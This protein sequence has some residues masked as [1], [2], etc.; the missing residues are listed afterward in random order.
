[1]AQKVTENET[2]KVEATPAVPTRNKTSRTRLL[3]LLSGTCALVIIALVLVGLNAYIYIQNQQYIHNQQAQADGQYQ[4]SSG[5]QGTDLG[6]TP[7]PNFQLVDQNGKSISLQQFHGHPVVLTFLYTTCPGPCPLTA[8]KLSSAVKLLGP[9]TSSKV[10]WLAVSLSPSTDNA[11]LATAFVNAHGLTGYMHYL[12]GSQQQLS[13]VW[14]NYSITVIPPKGNA[15][16]IHTVSVYVIDG[17]G[18]ERAYLDSDFTPQMLQQDL[19]ML[20]SQS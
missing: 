19:Q 14:K 12:L 1:M 6:S 4:N 15:S 20:L 9:Q 17:Q 7:A 5:L 13:P 10:S 3:I 16:L 8:E 11:G 2:P 18:H